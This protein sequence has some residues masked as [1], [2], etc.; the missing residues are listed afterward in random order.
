M[1][2]YPLNIP[3]RIDLHGFENSALTTPHRIL[4]AAGRTAFAALPICRET[5]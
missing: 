2:V 5:T 3:V 4:H 1:S